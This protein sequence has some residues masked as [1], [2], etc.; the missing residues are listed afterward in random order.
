[1]EVEKTNRDKIGCRPK[2]T[3]SVESLWNKERS[4][5]NGVLRAVE[6]VER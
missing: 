2:H 5:R 1:M 6:N 4:C 3:L